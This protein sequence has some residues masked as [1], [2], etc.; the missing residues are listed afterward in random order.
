MLRVLRHGSAASAND[1]DPAGIHEGAER[2]GHA[3]GRLVV[4]T[5]FI[6]QASVRYHRNREA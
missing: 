5:V 1:V 3:L 2:G 4:V 6:R